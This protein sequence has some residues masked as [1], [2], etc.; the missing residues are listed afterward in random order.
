[1]KLVEDV[2][3]ALLL[4]ESDTEGV[5][6]GGV[7]GFT[8][9]STGA[10]VEG[11]MVVDS[12]EGSSVVFVISVVGGGPTVVGGMV[13]IEIEVGGGVPDPA[14]DGVKVPAGDGGADPGTVVVAGGAVTFPVFG[15]TVSFPPVVGGG[16]AINAPVVTMYALT[17]PVVSAT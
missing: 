4:S 10:S 2:C 7:G 8:G 5:T 14:A 1:M 15:G 9:A 3:C 11:A 12:T 13:A 17:T 6:V 16:V